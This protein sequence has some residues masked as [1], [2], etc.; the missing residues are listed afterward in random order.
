MGGKNNH[1][2]ES[3]NTAEG[4]VKMR[5]ADGIHFTVEGQKIIAHNILQYL[6]LA[7]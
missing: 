3:M 7:N 2:T 5:S 6:H 1:F 4:N